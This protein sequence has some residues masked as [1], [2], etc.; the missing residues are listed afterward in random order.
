[1]GTELGQQG[2]LLDYI[3][4]TYIKTHRRSHTSQTEK[5][6]YTICCDLFFRIDAKRILILFPRQIVF[7]I[8]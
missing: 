4:P 6:I 2:S 7:E 8:N 5:F 1:M 3:R